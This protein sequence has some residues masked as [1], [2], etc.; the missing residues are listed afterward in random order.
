MKEEIY[1]KINTENKKIV[2]F[3]IDI[4]ESED[5]NNL[6]ELKNYQEK[7]FQKNGKYISDKEKIN[8]CINLIN[9]SSYM[10]EDLDFLEI[11]DLTNMK[12]KLRD[13]SCSDL[14]K[15][16]L[17]IKIFA[18]VNYNMMLPYDAYKFILDDYI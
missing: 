8:Y 17:I 5:I 7:L 1:K 2:E 3:L 12:Y 4:I 13:S 11:R 18:L 9:N 6:E 15:K 16:I 10:S 14:E